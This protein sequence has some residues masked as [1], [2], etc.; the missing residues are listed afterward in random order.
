MK[1]V[2]LTHP[3]ETIIADT[4]NIA[5]AGSEQQFTCA[6]DDTIMRAALRAGIGMPYEC[7]VGSCGTCKIELVSG[8]VVSN[9]PDAPALGERDRSRG[10]VLGCQSRPAGDCVVKAR[11]GPQYLTAHAPQ[12]FQATLDETRDLTH[13]IREFRFKLK[14]RVPFLPGQYA[15][16]HIP[17]VEGPRAYSMSNLAQDAD[18]A[19]HFQI[20]R[21]P[22]G[23]GTGAMFDQVR[24]GDT[25]AID[26]PYGLA[27]LR[28]DSPR[29]IIC[30]AGGSGL[31]PMVSIARGVAATAAMSGV[32]VHLFYGGR[33]ARDICGEDMIQALPGYGERFFFHPIISMPDAAS[34]E[35]WTGKVG[36]VHELALEMH[37]PRL[38]EHEIYFAGPPMM[39]QA[40]QKMLMQEKVPG[41]QVHYDAFY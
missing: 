25:I 35:E 19:W 40:V 17:G 13:D 20:K 29:D 37:G 33:G 15:L 16:L 27:Y 23:K 11:P 12:R 38:P 6:A 10:R 18:G 32:K 34:P 39:A 26:G 14:E 36:F 4:F 5:L 31:A 9:W 41:A 28:T 21:T 2:F 8:E 22:Q 30:I 1:C 7:N 24:I 3:L